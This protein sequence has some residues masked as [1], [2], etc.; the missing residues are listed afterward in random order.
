MQPHH[1][2]RWAAGFGEKKGAARFGKKKGAAGFG[3]KKGA[4]PKN[5]QMQKQKLMTQRRWAA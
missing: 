2:Q 4:P 1:P 5:P 3:K